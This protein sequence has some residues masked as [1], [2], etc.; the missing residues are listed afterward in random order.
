MSRLES[1]TAWFDDDNRSV[2]WDCAATAACSAA[3]D[4]DDMNA[5]DPLGSE[6]EEEESDVEDEG[7]EEGSGSGSDDEEGGRLLKATLEARQ[8]ARAA[9]DHPLQQSFRAAAAQLLEK[10][11]T[12]S[13]QQQKKHGKKK[14]DQK[15]S[16]NQTAE[17]QGEIN[18]EEDSEAE[19]AAEEEDEDSE[20][21]S[22]LVDSEADKESAGEDEEEQE[23]GADSPQ[24]AAAQT[25]RLRTDRQNT[26]AEAQ[27]SG[28]QHDTL[29]HDPSPEEADDLPYTIAAPST[30]AAFA[31]LVTGHSPA[32]LRLIVQRIRA[33]N[34][35]ALATDNR[36]KL[37][38]SLTPIG[39]S[40]LLATGDF[41]QN[42]ALQLVACQMHQACNITPAL[43]TGLAKRH[44][45]VY[46][47]HTHCSS[48]GENVKPIS[49]HPTRRKTASNKQ[50]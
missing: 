32:K 14:G 4:K 43:R 29:H 1:D 39:L 40:R 18:E 44:S 45:F 34:A 46:H 7:S 6:D 2:L 50:D 25:E 13:E 48:P 10:Y 36:R 8:A 16:R 28:H 20:Q 38:A 17:A 23:S 33:C 31:Q 12:A 47:V 3:G 35:I 37:Q 30:Y 49:M 26:H 22:E 9:G 5:D 11:G 42:S 21:G 27:S 41:M 15:L 24:S 19:A